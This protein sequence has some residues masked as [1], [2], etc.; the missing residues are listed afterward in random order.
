MATKFAEGFCPQLPVMFFGA[1]ED[2]GD[3]SFYPV[4]QTEQP[5]FGG[6]LLKL[7]YS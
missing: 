3:G 7:F 6:F 4:S 2:S 1:N 5:Q